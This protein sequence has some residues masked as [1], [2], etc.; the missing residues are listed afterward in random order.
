[1]RHLVLGVLFL[2]VSLAGSPVSACHDGSPLVLD[3]DGD[4]FW[5]TGP[6]DPTWFDLD[7]DGLRE[8]ITWNHR[9]SND[10]FL[11]FDRNGNGE[12][13]GGAELF[14]DATPLPS[15]K[16]AANGFEALAAFDSPSEG[17][18]GDQVIT[19]ADAIWH[20][21]QLWIDGDADGT[22]DPGESGPLARWSVLGISLA[23]LDSDEFDGNGNRHKYVSLYLKR[24]RGR[25]VQR[26]IDDVFFF[27]AVPE[28]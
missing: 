10:G 7:G 20:D 28:N 16:V 1:M 13:D 27:R 8:L 18:D 14:G 11:W 22:L 26:R 6:E 12:V 24:E 5:G 23:Y 9:H 2:T 21:L 15:G 25:I 4:G 19:A 17:G 3:L